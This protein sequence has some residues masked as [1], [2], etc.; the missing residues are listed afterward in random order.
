MKYHN[1]CFG[2]PWGGLKL[3]EINNDIK[4]TLSHK[5]KCNDS[6]TKR[7]VAYKNAFSIIKIRSLR[8]NNKV[9][10][11]RILNA[12][13]EGFRNIEN[14]SLKFGTGITSLVSVNSYGKSNLMNAI[15]F[16]VDFIKEDPDMKHRMMSAVYG[17][18]LNKK[19]DSKNYIADLTFQMKIN[20]R[21]YVTNY[22]F[23]FVWIKNN[24]K[25]V[26]GC[27]I[28]KEW[29]TA[30][31]DEKYQKPNKLIWRDEKKSLYKSSESGRCSNVIKVE[32]NELII[33]KLLAYEDLF[34][35]PIIENLNNVKIYV[36][37]DFDAAPLYVKTPIIPKGSD[38]FDFSSIN[39][40]P[41]IVYKLKTGYPDQYEILMDTFMQLFPNIFSIDVKEVDLGELHG[42]ELPVNAPYIISNKVY[43]MFV[44]DKNLNQPLNFESLSDGAKRV[45]LMLTYTIL[46]K[47]NGYHLIAFEEP[48]NS[49]HPSLLQ[50]YLS[51]LSQLAGDCRIIV[52]SHSPYIVQ[53]V[54]TKDIYIGKPNTDGIA[55]FA[56]VDEKKV[57]TLLSDAANNSDSVGNYIFDL[58]SGG[59]D[60]TEIL[61]S[62]LEN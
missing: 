39:D 19:L 20:E 26:S 42:M 45:F 27:K 54:S 52:A 9:I 43:S 47:I 40:V 41:R 25:G 13:I 17:M 3:Y 33:N 14:D 18:P 31:I 56:K 50:S 37:R 30:R 22:G 49:I 7:N 58:L 44:Q 53:Y 15:Q 21:T 10:S 59:E 8:L 29:L 32:E 62:Y 38:T 61:L 57:N 1:N 28:V 34:Y 11:M 2:K 16:A 36:E 5:K 12:R 35:R 48:E 46:A 60:D 6:K 55:D 23:S 4:Q 24:G 51:V